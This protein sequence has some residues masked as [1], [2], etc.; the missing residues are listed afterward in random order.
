MIERYGI[1]PCVNVPFGTDISPYQF[2]IPNIHHLQPAL[3]I[4]DLSVGTY[5]GQHL[6]R[7]VLLC[8]LISCDALT[9]HETV[10][11]TVQKLPD[12]CF[13]KSRKAR[14]WQGELG[15]K[16]RTSEPHTEELA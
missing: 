7:R 10:T 14:F 12:V 4:G 8:F 15:N 1:L 13:T 5:S 3:T 6:V 9:G 2:R 11:S 16:L